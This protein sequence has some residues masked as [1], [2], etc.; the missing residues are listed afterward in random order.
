MIGITGVA[1][2][3]K[4]TLYKLIE[5]RFQKEN[6]VTKRYALADNLKNDLKDFISDKFNINLN[7]SS[8]E[9]KE[10]VR[11]IMVAYGKCKRRQSLGRHWIDLLNKQ[12]KEDKLLPVVTDI[13]YDEYEKDE[14]F[15]LKKEKNGFLIHISRVHNGK[16]IPPANEE[17]NINN[18]ILESKSDYKM[19]WCTESNMDI[20]YSSYEKNLNE[21]YEQYSRSRLN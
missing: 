18:K 19:I 2:S 14:F 17:E 8:G 4:D 16:I 12:I 15:W 5:K 6:I 7:K 20:L 10:I 21:I 11:P 9:D 3:G 13:R 1:T